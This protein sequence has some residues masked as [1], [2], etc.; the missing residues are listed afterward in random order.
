MAHI[1]PQSLTVK[2]F[3]MK[4]EMG[5]FMENWQ[6]PCLTEKKTSYPQCRVECSPFIFIGCH[7]FYPSSDFAKNPNKP[8]ERTEEKASFGACASNSDKKRATT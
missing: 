2:E 5:C 6:P 8:V 4:C 3:I 7:G 1:L